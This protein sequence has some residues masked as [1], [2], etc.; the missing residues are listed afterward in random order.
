M[1]GTT[2]TL[3]D[4]VRWHYVPELHGPLAEVEERLRQ[5]KLCCRCRGESLGVLRIRVERILSGKCPRMF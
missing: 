2:P 4:E 5:C 1:E 3:D